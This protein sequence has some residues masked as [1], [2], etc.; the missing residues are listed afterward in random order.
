MDQHKEE[1]RTTVPFTA[2]PVRESPTVTEWTNRSVWTK[3]MLAALRNGV[4]GGRWHTLMDHQRWLYAFS[5]EGELFSLQTAH[6]NFCQ[7]S[8]R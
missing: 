1:R 3:P 2:I 6:Q 4:R 5:E 8:R 7:S